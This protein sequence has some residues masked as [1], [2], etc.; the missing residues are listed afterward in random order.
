[1]DNMSDINLYPINSISKGEDVNISNAIFGNRFHKDQTVYEYLIEFLL[2][3]VSSKDSD[4]DKGKFEFHNSN[5]DTMQYF[6]DPRI[7]LKRF[8][9]FDKSKKSGSIY[10]DKLA[11]NSLF[12]ELIK[13]IQI[14][15]NGADEGKDLVNYLQDFLFGYAVI[16]KNRAWCAQ[17]MLPICPEL[18]FCEAMPAEKHR[19]KTI[20][21][22]EYKSKKIDSEFEFSQHNFLARGGE[23]YYLHIVQGLK[24]DYEKKKKLEYLL[25][26]LVTNQSSKV[27]SIA[28]FIQDT[29][30]SVLGEDEISFRHEYKLGFIPSN[31]YLSIETKSIDELITFL[32]NKLPIV[33]K[34]ELLSQGIIF[35]IMRMMTTR[36]ANYLEIEKKSWI[37]DMGCSGNR[38]VKI[39]ACNSFQ[40]IE[41]DFT[42][43]LNK[44]IDTRQNKDEAEKYSKF[45]DGKKESLGIFRAKGKDIKCIIPIKG[46]FERFTLSEDIVTFLVLSLIRPKSQ[47]TLD[48][49]L[50]LIYDNYGIV[51]GINEYMRSNSDIQEDMKSISISFNR[52]VAAFEKFL[53]ETGFLQELSDA[54]SVVINPYEEILINEE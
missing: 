8:I 13:K 22:D 24:D 47:M 2:I 37:V 54:T 43:A 14:D 12:D 48:M 11:Y 10:A 28:N 34:L 6:V 41:N 1:M 36:V 44:E 18:I 4:S 35:Q 33:R 7:G 38:I 16:L 20:A 52:N 50:S 3:F 53:K 31:G 5:L 51:I 26:D 17:A 29:W 23:L 19:R 42:T 45:L 39:M 32:S 49:F 25:K 40:D 21:P 15:S 46:G 27:S 30:Y 9:F